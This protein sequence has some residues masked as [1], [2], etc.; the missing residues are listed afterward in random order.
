MLVTVFSLSL[1]VGHAQKV[2][3][4][5][6]AFDVQWACFG[7]ETFE[8]C[9]NFIISASEEAVIPPPA[10]ELCNSQLAV[11]PASLVRALGLERQ[12]IAM[13]SLT[14]PT[15]RSNS[16]S[17]DVG[18]FLWDPITESQVL[19][20]LDTISFPF[21]LQMA[22]PSDYVSI[23]SD[24]SAS[25]GMH[26]LLHHRI[27]TPANLQT[28]FVFLTIPYSMFVDLD[29]AFQGIDN[30]RIHAASVC[31]IEQPAFVSGQHVLVLELSVNDTST[32]EFSTKL[33]LRYP[34]PSRSYE[35][36]AFLPEPQLLC[37][38]TN[39]PMLFQE[40]EERETPTYIW[41]AAGSDEDYDLVMWITVLV[42]WIGVVWMMLDMSSVAKWD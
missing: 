8:T 16:S 42:C 37:L 26:R 13:Y 31:D 32:L 30:V 2:L 27:R 7:V 15:E 4:T 12:Q 35:Q 36:Q 28:G 23:H 6:T 39:G 14:L 19:Q 38:N 1:A 11:V 33:H 5:K 9:C 41:V 24:L 10:F 17:T 20:K 21:L 18:Q 29:D 3:M 34:Y 40:P 25:G 22:E